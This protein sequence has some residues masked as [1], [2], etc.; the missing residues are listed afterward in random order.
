M[1]RVAFL[2]SPE[3]AVPTL[4][5]LAGVF[6]VVRVITQPDRPK[7]RSKTPTPTPVKAAAQEL[8]MPV[9]TPGDANALRQALTDVAPLDLAVVVA[10]GR[11]LPPDV[12]EVPELGFLNVHFSLLPRWRGAAP[13]ARAL[14]A[15]DTMTGVT[16]IR[17]D[18]GLDTGPVLTAQGVDIHP[19]E[20]RGELTTRLAVVGARLV[21][22]VIPDYVS[23]VV[24]PVDQSDEGLTY[25]AKLTASDRPIRVEWSA[26][27]VVNHVRG[28]SPEPGATLLLDDQPTQVTRARRDGSTPDQGKWAVVGDRLVAGFADGGVE[29]VEIKPPGKKTMTGSAWLRGRGRM[30]GVLG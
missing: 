1:T 10:Y 30:T 20:T 27:E 15:G 8:G 26:A 12:L 11:L 19:D 25:A 7:G 5:T 21:T 14:M 3:A 9:S 29:L 16:I 13:V 4:K 18:E 22:N 23:K 2:G 6:D 17:L 28:L 24:E